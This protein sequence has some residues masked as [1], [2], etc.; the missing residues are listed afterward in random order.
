M[1]KRVSSQVAARPDPHSCA[2]PTADEET[3]HPCAITAGARPL[4]PVCSETMHTE[5]QAHR[6][7]SLRVTSETRWTT[8]RHR[9]QHRSRQV[10]AP[11]AWSGQRMHDARN[12]NDAQR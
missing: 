10:Q 7:T 3:A 12:S 8:G 6:M 5:N 9:P 4:H 2:V 11:A 1:T